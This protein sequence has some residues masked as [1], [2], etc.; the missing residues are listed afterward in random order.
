MVAMMS[1][2]CSMMCSARIWSKEL[3]RKGKPPWSR[4]QRTSA[5]VDGF[6]SRPMEPGYFVGPQP[7]SRMRG[8]AAPAE[9]FA[10][11]FQFLTNTKRDAANKI[12]QACWCRPVLFAMRLNACQGAAQ[13]ILRPAGG[14]GAGLRMTMLVRSSHGAFDFGDARVH[15]ADGEFGLLFVNQQRRA[16][17]QGGVARA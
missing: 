5:A 17:A 8:K 7:T 15:C 10:A 4:W 16:E 2:T 13:E 11:N 9:D 1:A 14:K 12:A 6:I 3:S